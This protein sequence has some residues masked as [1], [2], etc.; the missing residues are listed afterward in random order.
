MKM[1]PSHHTDQSKQKGKQA[2][3]ALGWLERAFESGDTTTRL[4][5]VPCTSEIRLDPSYNRCG[6]A[7]EFA[8]AG[9]TRRGENLRCDLVSQL[10][11][12]SS[13]IN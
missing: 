2:V 1:H 3:L 7:I 11:L 4:Y 8:Q 6:G 13:H 5:C 9:G 12:W 10:T